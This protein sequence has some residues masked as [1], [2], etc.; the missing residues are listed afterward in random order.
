MK[1]GLERRLTKGDKAGG[2]PAWPPEHSLQKIWR[3]SCGLNCMRMILS[4]YRIRVT[5]KALRD[6]YRAVLGLSEAE[7]YTLGG[8]HTRD[9]VAVLAR[10]ARPHQRRVEVHTM[11][12]GGASV[13]A[14]LGQISR[15]AAEQR[16]VMVTYAWSSG[17][18]AVLHAGLF[19]GMAPG[20][21]AMMMDPVMYYHQHG[22]TPWPGEA[23]ERFLPRWAIS[24]QERLVVTLE[25]V[26]P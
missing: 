19:F 15:A 6:H 20:G 4:G 14:A 3:W 17:R 9:D 1:R 12:V 25:A 2:P 24:D 16:P 26:E 18:W 22:P 10:A 23:G 21:K 5:R 8:T 13:E 7:M 11:E